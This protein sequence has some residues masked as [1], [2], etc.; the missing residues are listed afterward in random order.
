VRKTGNR[1]REIRE[2]NLSPRWDG[3]VEGT[4]RGKGACLA[5]PRLASYLSPKSF[6]FFSLSGFLS[7]LSGR[8]YGGGCYFLESIDASDASGELEMK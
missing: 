2:I 1:K 6:L 7:V 4:D 8:N 5:S 3:G